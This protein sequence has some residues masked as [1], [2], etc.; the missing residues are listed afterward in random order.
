MLQKIFY[1]F[2]DLSTLDEYILQQYVP[3]LNHLIDIIEKRQS[4][5]DED[6]DLITLIANCCVAEFL[7]LSTNCL[8]DGI[9]T[10]HN[11]LVWIIT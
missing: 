8:N 3:L 4:H 2:T 10:T 6:D 1:Y 9:L 7:R 11:I 5:N